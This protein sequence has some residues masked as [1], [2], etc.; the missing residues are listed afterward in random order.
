MASLLEAAL[1]DAAEVVLRRNRFPLRQQPGSPA[2]FPHHRPLAQSTAAPQTDKLRQGR[3][4]RPDFENRK[5]RTLPRPAHPAATGAS[6]RTLFLK[7]PILA[8]ARRRARSRSAPGS[9][10][11][12]AVAFALPPQ[13]RPARAAREAVGRA[14]RLPSAPFRPPRTGKLREYNQELAESRS[15]NVL[16]GHNVDAHLRSSERIP[17]SPVHPS[18]LQAHS[19][20]Y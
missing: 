4:T 13:T 20:Q 16:D 9:L 1:L 17:P 14:S 6:K 19:A 5:I 8:E 15:L 18:P 10:R 2:S 12:V 3:E 7:N 11:H